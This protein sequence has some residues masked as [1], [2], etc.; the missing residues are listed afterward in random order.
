MELLGNVKTYEW[1]KVGSNSKVA[2]LAQLN[3][4]DGFKLDEKQPYSELWVN[5]L[6]AEGVVNRFRLSFIEETAPTHM[7]QVIQPN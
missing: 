2:Q 5:G 7:Y 3:A 4:G 1:G 6:S